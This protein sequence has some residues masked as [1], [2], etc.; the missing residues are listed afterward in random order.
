MSEGIK[1]LGKHTAI[2]GLGGIISRLA[3]FLM[4]P[5]YT[6]F[7][8]PSDYGVLELL[9]M[10]ID[11]FAAMAGM[12]IALSVF[13]FYADFDTPEDHARVASTASLSVISIAAAT[14][15]LGF[16]LAPVLSDI[17]LKGA[18][19]P[20]YFRLFFVIYFF[21]VVESVPLLMLR[22]LQRSRAFVALSV[23]KLIAMLA[24]NIYFVVVL[25]MGVMGVLLSNLLVSSVTAV[26]LA[27][28]LFRRVGVRFSP[29]LLRRMTRYGIPLVLVNLGN[30]IIVF[31]DRFF[32]NHFVTTAAVGI[33]ALAYKFAFLLSAM[34]F[35][36]F[37]MV[38][39][40]YRFSIAKEAD[41]D[42]VFARVFL[43][44]NIVLGLGA[45]GIAIFVRDILTLMADPAFH[46]A[47]LFVPVLLTAQILQ[48]W[49]V[50][51]NV[52]FLLREKTGAFAWASGA[53]VLAA[54]VLNAALIPAYGIGGAV[55]A[56]FGAYLVRF[57]TVFRFSQRQYRIPYDW[58]RVG[59]LYAILGL[60]VAARLIA[61][62]VPLPQAL[63]L[64]TL[65]CLLAFGAVYALFLNPGERTNL[66]ATIRRTKAS[67]EAR[68]VDQ[69]STN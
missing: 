14:A 7:L 26:G 36:P 34:T 58:R 48:S 47:F 25:R 20:L 28:F 29:T 9:A 23:G 50:Y 65:L 21:Q 4:L 1:T 17:V 24:L 59:R 8:T 13:K 53:G 61:G 46:A 64:D 68:P 45:L 33:Y 22:V 60:I 38:W 16:L 51:C 37:N 30:F 52:G 42:V 18:G 19:P 2:Y 10:T 55:A 41:G 49:T 31:S 32:L 44:L 5:I 57:L 12:G 69:P 39:G 6:R 15:C 62:S 54:L 67:A 40:P 11:L 43:Y 27:V 35:E 3:S 56:T 63:L 66:M